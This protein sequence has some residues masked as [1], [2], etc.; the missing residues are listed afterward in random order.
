MPSFSS[1]SVLALAA[2]GP[3]FSTGQKG[4]FIREATSTLI[5]PKG[6]NGG[7]VSLWVGMGTTKGDLI[8]SIADNTGRPQWSIFAYTLV[9]KGD[10]TQEPVAAPGED[11][12]AEDRVTMHCE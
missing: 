8:Q 5:L 11:A 1:L 4:T 3:A 12:N 10:G 2:F 6:G 9:L 7:S